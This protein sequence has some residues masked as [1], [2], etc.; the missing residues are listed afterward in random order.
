[1][2]TITTTLVA[3]LGILAFYQV[4][5]TVIFFWQT[6]RLATPHDSNVELPKTAILLALRGADPDLEL[7][8]RRLMTQDY[9]NYELHVVI[10]SETDPAWQLVQRAIAETG[11][12]HVKHTALRDRPDQC[13]LHCASL[14]QLAEDLD[15]SFEVF[16]LADGDLVAHPTWLRE[17][18]AP[19]ACGRA[20]AASGNRWYVPTKGQFG[21]IVR[22]FWNAAA[23]ISMHF[24]GIPWGGTFAGRTKDLRA[25]G[26]INK[27]RRALAVDAPIRTCWQEIDKRIEFV[28]SLIM[29]NR[30]EIHV[31]PC[32]GFI[33]RQLM[34]TRL[35]QPLAFWAS[36]VL[37][38]WVTSATLL[39]TL[40]IG[41]YGLCT[42]QASL[43]WMA[44]GGL[45]TYIS[46]MGLSVL[47]LEL[48]VRKTISA[49]G[50]SAAWINPASALK[51]VAA[52]PAAQ[53]VHF[54]AIANV[55]TKRRLDWRGV[56]Y[57]IRSPLDVRKLVD[58][59]LDPNVQ[60]DSVQS[61]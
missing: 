50:Q 41:V 30:E 31:T 18:V 43:A 56:I 38:A 26:L 2:L 39:V 60:V 1:M 57:E 19:I 45:A 44:V 11:A 54:L 28:P 22:Y 27:W 34:W 58:K 6:R 40:A 24:F 4:V 35:Y 13:S 47:L 29:P 25:S 20:D 23:V 59:P 10:D 5:V 7:G 51:L 17:L 8:L 33:S 37:H 14:V 46:A 55:I 42:Q 48:R 49:N 61:I 36:I 15:E 3:A 32:F 9:P 52:I 16:A 21:S 53:I 12:K